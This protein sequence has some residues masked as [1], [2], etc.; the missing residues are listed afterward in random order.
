VRVSGLNIDECWPISVAHP[1]R[2]AVRVMMMVAVMVVA[3][4]G[5]KWELRA[6][7]ESRQTLN[8]EGRKQIFD[9]FHLNFE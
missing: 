4:H 5:T 7:C 9:A 1:R 3:N 2:R 8:Q 6:G